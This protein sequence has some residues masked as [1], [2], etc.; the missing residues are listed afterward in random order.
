MSAALMERRGL[1]GIGGGPQEISRNLVDTP[2]V[3]IRKEDG[4]KFINQYETL[5]ELGKG[6]FGKVK[7]IKHTETGELFALKVF[8]KNVLRKKRMGTRNMLQ[9]VEHEIR[10]MKQMDH[11]SCI[12]LYEVLDSPDYHKLFLRLEYCEGGHPI[13]TENLPTDPLPEAAARKYFRGLLDGLDYIHSSNIIHRDIKPENLLLTKDG[14]IKLADFG[15]GQVL[16]DG[17]DLINKSAGTPAF[18][19][20]EACV[21]GDFSGKGADIWAAGVT[22]YLFVHGKCPFISNNLVQIFQMIREDP[23]EF[24]PTLSHNCRDLLEKILEK[25]PKK[26]IQIPDIKNHEWLKED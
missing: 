15:T 19:A 11:P 26:R 4:R 14:M 23:I 6:S 16:E 20:P 18:T 10:I 8:N 2:I 13:C 12:K 17:N 25:D 3:T 24:S 22:L 1:M 9:D 21:E 5:K 7:L